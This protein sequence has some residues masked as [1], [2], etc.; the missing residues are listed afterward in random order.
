MGGSGWGAQNDG[1]RMGAV[2]SK[3]RDIGDSSKNA[4]KFAIDIRRANLLAVRTTN[5]PARKWAMRN[6]GGTGGFPVPPCRY[7]IRSG[8]S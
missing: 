7:K 5:H 4:G 1:L 3:K 2:Y 8:Y 6:K